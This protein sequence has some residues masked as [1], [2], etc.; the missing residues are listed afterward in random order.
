MC[1]FPSYS[2]LRTFKRGRIPGARSWEL[3]AGLGKEYSK[4][5]AQLDE[6]L[7][8]LDLEVKKVEG[9]CEAS[10]SIFVVTQICNYW[11][12][13][14]Q[15]VPSFEFEELV[16]VAPAAHALRVLQNFRIHDNALY[17]VE[18]RD[19]PYGIA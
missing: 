2:A 7:K 8:D 15:N 17:V 12:Q 6:S 5:L 18:R 13:N 9:Q 1:E 19:T 11:F 16:R 3:K 10:V 14:F 4:V